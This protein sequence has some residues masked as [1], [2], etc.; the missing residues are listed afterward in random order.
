MPAVQE[1]T[2]TEAEKADDSV[3]PH[4]DMIIRELQSIC[5]TILSFDFITFLMRSY[6][7]E[8]VFTDITRFKCNGFIMAAF[9][10][11]TGTAAVVN[12]FHFV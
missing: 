3:I 8:T 7:L 2:G 4:E 12:S 6:I 11:G 10:Y 1:E 9:T 5:R